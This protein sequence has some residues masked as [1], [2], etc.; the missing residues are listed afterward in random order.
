MKKLASTMP[1]C[2][3]TASQPCLSFL[4][5]TPLNY[6]KKNFLIQQ[7]QHRAIQMAAIMQLPTQSTNISLTWTLIEN[8]A[9]QS[10]NTNCRALLS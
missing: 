9:L 1:V 7:K 10:Y 3:D 6:M 4:V 8:I 2:L 5:V